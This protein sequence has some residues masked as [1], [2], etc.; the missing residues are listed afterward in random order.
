LGESYFFLPTSLVFFAVFFTALFAFVAFLAFF[1]MLPSGVRWLGSLR[2]LGNRDAQR[3]E[4]TNTSKKNSVQLKEVL[5]SQNANSERA[6]DASTAL[7]VHHIQDVQHRSTSA[8]VDI[9]RSELAL[10]LARSS[11]KQITR[12][13][14][15]IPVPSSGAQSVMSQASLILSDHRSWPRPDA[16][17]TGTLSLS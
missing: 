2:A 15:I 16:P 9:A 14:S 1:A 8:L 11:I 13:V 5:M 10:P 6:A 4:Y 3:P 17:A 7:R 12:F